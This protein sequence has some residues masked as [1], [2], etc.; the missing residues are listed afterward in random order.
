MIEVEIDKGSGFCF[1]VVNA[2]ES[3]EREL[4]N[5]DRLYCLGDIVHNSLEVERLEAAGLRTIDHE[6]FGKILAKLAKRVRRRH[7]M[8]AIP[9]EIMQE[10]PDKS[11]ERRKDD[12]VGAVKRY[13]REHIKEDIYIADILLM[14]TAWICLARALWIKVSGNRIQWK[15][16]MRRQT[17]RLT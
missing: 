14:Q 4:K 17:S 9:S 2:I 3:A 13:V 6:E 7:R 10:G 1:G 15:S 5:T 12:V 11:S 16:S 8:E